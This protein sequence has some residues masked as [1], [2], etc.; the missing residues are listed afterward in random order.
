MWWRALLLAAVFVLAGPGATAGEA[1]R[2]ALH[3]QANS[4]RQEIERL[5]ENRSQ[6]AAQ[7]DQWQARLDGLA[8]E[9]D[10]RKAGHGQGSLFPNFGL[11]QLL[12]R[13][14]ET[15][16]GLTH[17]HRELV[18]LQEKRTEHLEQL[19]WLL[20]ALVQAS[21]ENIRSLP[22]AARAGQLGELGRLRQERLSVQQALFAGLRPAAA[23]MK[24]QGLLSADDPEELIERADAVRDEQDRLRRQLSGLDQHI[25]QARAEIRLNREM[26][27]FMADH[28]L[29]GEGLR[30]LKVSRINP[31]A[32]K[33]SDGDAASDD[34]PAG[35]DTGFAVDPDDNREGGIGECTGG[36]CG[37]PSESGGGAYDTAIAEPVLSE[38]SVPIG[39]E[40]APPPTQNLSPS[41]YLEAL[42]RQRHRIVTRIKTFQI[43]QDRLM[44]KAD[45][46]E[47]E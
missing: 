18:A 2:N 6:L 12:R 1:D 33:T 8:S 41:Q 15:A 38:G 21:A 46:L 20:G 36:D 40:Q 35:E 14:Q 44:E 17:L 34:P 13:S 3:Q 26:S 24:T 31:S 28:S 39:V 32:D 45:R 11:Q 25:R 7:R 30:I 9:I 19:E 29:F 16:A 22:K 42:R 27:D 4:L 10:R 23:P 43:L 47:A 5:S 37:T